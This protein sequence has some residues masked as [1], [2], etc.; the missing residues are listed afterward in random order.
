MVS[1]EMRNC[2]RT[3]AEIHRVDVNDDGVKGDNLMITQ[4]GHSST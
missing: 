1:P 2:S 4:P 3:R